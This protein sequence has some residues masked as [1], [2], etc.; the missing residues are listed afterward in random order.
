[1]FVLIYHK[2][3]TC[4]TRLCRYINS[5]ESVGATLDPECSWAHFSSAVTTLK[6]G[7]EYSRKQR[8][9]SHMYTLLVTW[10]LFFFSPTNGPNLL[11]LGMTRVAQT[12]EN[13]KEKHLGAVTW[14]MF[15]LSSTKCV[16]IY[17]QF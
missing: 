11:P 12:P 13:K 3:F 1:M 4:D 2:T 15:A 9:T 8:L 16:E 5:V 6:G 10:D 17:A 14:E 7:G